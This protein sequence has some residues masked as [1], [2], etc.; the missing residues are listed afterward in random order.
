MDP[1]NLSSDCVKQL[2]WVLEDIRVLREKQIPSIQKQKRI[3]ELH[4]ELIGTF[5]LC[6]KGVK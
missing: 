2:T 5:E 1:K 6:L 3:D 4:R